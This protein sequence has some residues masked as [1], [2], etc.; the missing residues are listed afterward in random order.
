MAAL[1]F[2]FSTVI[3]TYQGTVDL[4]LFVIFM[5]ILVD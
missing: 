5:F 2:C 3:C 1:V 4:V